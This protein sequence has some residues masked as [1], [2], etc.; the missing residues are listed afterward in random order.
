MRAFLLCLV[1][2]AGLSAL[3]QHAVAARAPGD[4]WYTAPA[5]GRP[6]GE[7]AG[8]GLRLRLDGGALRDYL[9]ALPDAGVDG[10][11]PLVL[12][13]PDGRQVA[14]EVSRSQVMAPELAAKFPQLAT[15]QGAAV[16]GSGL[17]VR[18][19]LAAGEFS[20][21]LLGGGVR[22]IDRESASG[23]Y[24]VRDRER[25][26]DLPPFTCG[27]RFEDAGEAPKSFAPHLAADGPKATGPNLRIYRTAVAATGEYTAT[28]GGTVAGGLRGIVSAIN[29]VNQMYETDLGIRLVLV[30]GS[31][32]IV[33]T[34]AATD[35]YTNTS[36]SMM[37]GQNQTNLTNVI[38]AANYDFGH[39]FSTGGGGIASLNSVCSANAK[40]RGVTGQGAPNFDPFWVDYVAHE[41]GHQLNAPHTFNGSTGNCSGGNR[42]AAQAYE[43]GSGATIM[44]Y[45]GICGGENL[46]PNS[47]PFF[48][49]ASLQTIHAYTQTGTGSTCG[50]V[51]ATGNATP[52]VTATPNATIP[53]RTPFALTA[54]ASDP[55]AA[56]RLTYSWE[57]F[58]LDPTASNATT[59]SQDNGLRP[60][61]RT[62]DASDSP[63][64]LFPRL[65][66][67]LAGTQTIG[68]VLPTTNRSLNFRVV[69]RDNRGGVQW[70]GT[71]SPAVAQTTLTVVDTGAA[72]A[73]TTPNTVT[74][75]A[76]GS[77]Q[78]VAWDVGGTAAAPISCANVAIAWS[79]DGG[80]SFPVTLAAST[81]NDGSE[82]IT[83]PAQATTRGRLRVACVG[84]VFFDINNADVTVTGGNA[85]PV[86]TLPGGAASYTTN[87]PAVV[88]DAAATVADADS[89][90]FAGGA[91]TATLSNNGGF[92]DRLE[93]RNQGNG[94]GQV[95][96]SGATVSVGGTAVGTLAGGT[97]VVPLVVSFNA[98]ATP[99]AAQAVLR[100]LTFRSTDDVT[101]TLPRT[102]AVTIS[103]GDGGSSA[104]AT[105][106]INI[107][108]NLDPVVAFI[109]DGDIDNLIA[110]NRAQAWTVA[111]TKDIDLATV[112][113]A[114]FD[115]AGTAPIT[116]GAITEPS[117][118]VLAVP[119]TATG[120]GT[121]LLRLP[122]GASIL[123]ATGL[124]VAVPAV[125]NDPVVVDAVVPTLASIDDGDADNSAEVGVAL[126][127][128]LVF[129]EA[130]DLAS[131]TAL[132]F[133]NAGSATVTIGAITQAV[134]GTITV[135]VTPT[136]GGTLQLRLPAGATVTDVAG[137]PLSVPQQDNDILTVIADAV[138]ANSFEP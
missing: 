87:A 131:V 10:S 133:D 82:S 35:P 14:F 92:D 52:L 5:A 19:E 23:D 44:A 22:L 33:Y 40:A 102:V 18:F 11:L 8:S 104:P 137:N 62:F 95:G 20:A 119:V 1:G 6:A 28:Y 24:L 70:S 130:V 116:I 123:D 25:R 53:A 114:D 63:T 60:L 108:L 117:P 32:R 98:A 39:V 73:V 71:A 110:A 58:D 121:I 16:D 91:L 81:P 61:F 90:D 4:F 30:A 55:D 100:N 138:F 72:F 86:V 113:G 115:N 7:E 135:V 80:N 50:Q 99:A 79:T 68:E 89:A 128:T 31:E 134:A 74:S 37:L 65:A 43:P 64:R 101:G 124:A 107:L 136:G 132:D 41:M 57:Q 48:H 13:L 9:A 29:R 42:S 88:L 84:N 15:Y 112:S 17:R 111:F 12:P 118:G 54:S 78:P 27:V 76:A 125:D 129:S 127:Y 2:L 67:I 83:V 69:A 56:D 77:S 47:D 109:D 38:G 106:T 122:A 34:D 93:I 21:M 94:A 105:K 51:V 96:V 103:D 120:A 75:W 3:P 97:G 26:G 59:V 66:D 49:V 36:G 126:T 85:Q 46:Q 45:A